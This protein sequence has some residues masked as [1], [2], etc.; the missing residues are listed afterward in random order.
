MI[1]E[2]VGIREL[3]VGTNVGAL[4]GEGIQIPLLLINEEGQPVALT[5]SSKLL[6]VFVLGVL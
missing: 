6:A 3:T 1:G 2:A 4:V 5:G